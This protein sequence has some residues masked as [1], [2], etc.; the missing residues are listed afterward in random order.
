MTHMQS[1]KGFW[2][3]FLRVTLLTIAFFATVLLLS[4]WTYAI[5]KTMGW[6]WTSLDSSSFWLGV[7]L[8]LGLTFI[9]LSFI[10]VLVMKISKLGN[11]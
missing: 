10:T 9:G 6:S 4:D 11:G 7:L 2:W 3:Y 8:Y 1:Q 5:S